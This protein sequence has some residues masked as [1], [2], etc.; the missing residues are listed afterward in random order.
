MRKRI[1]AIIACL[2]FSGCES[3]PDLTIEPNY[4]GTASVGLAP[5]SFLL[6]SRLIE[7]DELD[8][9]VTAN[10]LEVSMVQQTSGVWEGTMLFNPG[11]NIEVLVAWSTK[12]GLPLA[13]ATRVAQVPTDGR[14]LNIEIPENIYYTIYD[15]DG[16]LRSNLSELRA[17]WDPTSTASPGVDPDPRDVQ[18]NFGIPPTLL[19]SLSVEAQNNL[20]MVV[21]L[22]NR[23][24]RL[25]YNAETRIWSGRGVAREGNDV[26]LDVTYYETP[27]HVNKLESFKLR[28]PVTSNGI[29]VNFYIDN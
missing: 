4:D 3:S 23:V 29:N 11:Q 24:F 2:V 21:L 13:N 12:S 20:S 9:D 7:V 1:L 18:F 19:Q 6:D 27:A 28:M 17:G 14:G 26:F 22:D 8:L 10:N 5:P 16:D 25:F 15:F